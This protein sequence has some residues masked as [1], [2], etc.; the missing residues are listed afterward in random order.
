MDVP[1]TAVDPVLA[2]SVPGGLSGN[3]AAS[4][5]LVLSAAAAEFVP[6][7]G[8]KAQ[9]KLV[10]RPS[11]ERSPRRPL[12]PPMASSASAVDETASGVACGD[13]S[14]ETFYVGQVV[15]LEGLESRPDLAGR[16]TILSFDE[17]TARVA[18][19][20]EVTGERIKVKK[21]FLHAL[22]FGPMGPP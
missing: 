14:L 13:T 11:R 12:S 1:M 3:P 8:P 4:P 6:S 7:A 22:P 10:A 9:R 18:I 20:A 15:M 19:C 21:K 5:P 17:V 16:A 2:A